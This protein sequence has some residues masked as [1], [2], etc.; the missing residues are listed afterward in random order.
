MQAPQLKSDLIEL[1]QRHR[2]CYFHSWSVCKRDGKW[3]F[4]PQ[5]DPRG[6]IFFSGEEL[7]PE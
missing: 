2:A 5:S 3:L 7:V 6:L 4:D 1:L